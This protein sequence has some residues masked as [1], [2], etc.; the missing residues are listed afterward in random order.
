MIAPST[1][2]TKNAMLIPIL[3]LKKRS[4]Q[5]HMLVARLHKAG[6]SGKGSAS[7]WRQAWMVW[8]GTFS[9]S[10]CA[11]NGDTH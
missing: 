4:L 5:G 3:L 6:D 2:G 1:S 7:L 10:S 8:Y 11:M 9:K